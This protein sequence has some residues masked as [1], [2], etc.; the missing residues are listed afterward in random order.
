[1]LRLLS[2]GAM[3]VAPIFLFILVLPIT[4]WEVN[5]RPV[6]YAEL[7][8]SG[9]GAAIASSLAL[10]ATGAWGIAARKAKS[11]WFLVASPLAPY[12]ILTLF[13]ASHAET[14]GPDVIASAGL[15]AVV[16]YFCLFRL[17]AVRAYLDAEGVGT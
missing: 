3:V 6:S 1:M 13:P 5:G 11:R 15:T 17:R 7:W 8:S 14:I 2:Q 12:I 4:D 10:I 16:F 9:E